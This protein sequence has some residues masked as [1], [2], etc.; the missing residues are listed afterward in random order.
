MIKEETPGPG[1]YKILN[2]YTGTYLD[3]EVHSRDVCCRPAKDLGEPGKGL[4]RWYPSSVFHVSDD[5]SEVGDQKVRGWVHGT[6]GEPTN[7]F[8]HRYLRTSNVVQS[9]RT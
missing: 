7:P 3:I 1:I 2:I 4:V 8:P 9:G 6:E 5:N